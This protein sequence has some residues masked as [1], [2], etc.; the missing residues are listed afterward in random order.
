VDDVN[1]RKQTS[2]VSE[3]HLATQPQFL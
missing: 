3:S 1:G 2:P